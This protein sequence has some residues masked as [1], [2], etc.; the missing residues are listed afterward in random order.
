M[1]RYCRE[2]P[3]VSPIKAALL[4]G[5]SRVVLMGAD[6][7]VP[8]VAAGGVIALVAHKHSGR[9]LPPVDNPRKAMGEHVIP[10]VARPPV[11]GW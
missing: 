8:R 7:E 3:N 5:V 6:K 10:A 2:S 4:H 9:N 1:R 11:A